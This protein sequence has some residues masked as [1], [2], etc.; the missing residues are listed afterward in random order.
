MA[1]VIQL[2]PAK[3]LNVDET[4]Y[5][6]MVNMMSKKELLHEMVLFQ[7]ERERVGHLTPS[8][9]VRGKHLFRVLEES[10]ETH[11]LRVLSRSYRRHL[12]TEITQLL[13]TS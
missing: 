8:M 2:F 5:I 13:E 6:G 12:E 11:E 10:A 4:P 9:M 7:E 3:L 1:K